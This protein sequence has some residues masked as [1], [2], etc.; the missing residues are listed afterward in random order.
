MAVLMF[1]PRFVR[2]VRSGVK[3]QTIRPVRKR[4]IE[5]GD[6]LALRYWSGLP[7]R[8]PQVTICYATCTAVWDIEIR[9]VDAGLSTCIVNGDEL[10]PFQRSTLARDDGF[11]DWAGMWDWFKANHG[12]PFKGVVISWKGTG[13]CQN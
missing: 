10:T 9:G 7:Y 12:L 4:P 13:P 8:S 11:D 2:L 6:A 1:K 3:Q 5:A